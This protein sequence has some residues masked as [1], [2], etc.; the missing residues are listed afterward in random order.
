[1]RHAPSIHYPATLAA[2][3]E[4][5][6]LDDILTC[7]DIPEITVRVDFWRRAGQAL[8]VR[9]RGLDLD[10]QEQVR[11]AAA[12][13]VATEDRALGVTQHWPIFVVTTLAHSFVSPRITIDQAQKLVRKNGAACEQLAKLAWDLSATSQERIDAILAEQSGLDLADGESAAAHES[14]HPASNE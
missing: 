3:E 5:A 10:Q 14:T 2:G 11:R 7:S 9:V 1:M 6:S 12:R 13:A 4:L 8:P